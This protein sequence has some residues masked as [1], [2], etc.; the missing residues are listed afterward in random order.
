MHDVTTWLTDNYNTHTVFPPQ[1][2]LNFETVR[3]SALFEGG[4]Y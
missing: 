2:L 3:C 1:R 4:A